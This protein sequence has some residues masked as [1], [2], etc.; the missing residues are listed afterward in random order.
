MCFH[1]APALCR[2]FHGIGQGWFHERQLFQ[3]RESLLE[4]KYR[5]EKISVFLN[6]AQHLV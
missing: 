4:R 2:T 3:V 1:A 5:L 6:P